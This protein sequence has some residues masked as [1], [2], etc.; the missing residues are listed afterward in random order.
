MSK[1]NKILKSSLRV[2]FVSHAYAIGMNQGKLNAIT[3][4]EGV[5]VGLLVPSN[6]KAREWNRLIPVE[7]PY[8]QIRIYSAPVQFSSR[9]GAHFYNPW[10]VW[11]VLTDFKP[12]IVQVEEEV[13]SLCTFELA[14]L[15]KLINRPLIVFGWENIER[16]LPFPRWLTCQFVLNTVSFLIPGNQDGANIMRQWGY[17]GLLEVMPQIGVDTH[18]FTSDLVK[19]DR[20]QF[21]IGFLGRLVPEKGIDLLLS[22]VRQLQ[23]RGLKC[24]LIICG[25]GSQETALRQQAKALQIEDWISWKGAILHEEAPTAISQFDV[26]VLPSR[27]ISN[28]KEQFGHVLIE[29]MAMGIPVIGSTCGEIPNVIQCNNL[30]FQEENIQELTTI[31]DRMIRNPHW[32]KE[33]ARH[34]INMVNKYYSHQRIAKR[35]LDVWHIISK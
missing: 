23:D 8:P 19:C 13:F 31:L 16:R 29:A 33:M 14:I 20:Q 15:T 10:Q 9:G 2:L 26:L 7:N 30:I 35:L 18:L 21:N 1:D 25:S 6:W 24:N 4:V 28:W 34:G 5:E 27:T 17:K 11:Q 32:R 22:S 3:E 12:D